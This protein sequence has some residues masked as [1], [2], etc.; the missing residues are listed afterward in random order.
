[1]VTN[2][3]QVLRI[4]HTTEFVGLVAV[5]FYCGNQGCSLV[6]SRALEIVYN[7][8]NRAL[9]VGDRHKFSFQKKLKDDIQHG[10]ALKKYV[11]LT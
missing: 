6:K 9:H 4:S 3:L 7:E 11:S 8:K 2:V 10:S 1:M 5:Q